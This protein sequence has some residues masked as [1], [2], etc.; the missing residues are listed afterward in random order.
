MKIY[1]SLSAIKDSLF[2]SGNGGYFHWRVHHSG[3]RRTYG[4]YSLTIDARNTTG[5]TLTHVTALPDYL[6][7][8]GFCYGHLINEIPSN[9]STGI[10]FRMYG[11]YDSLTCRL[12][13]TDGRASPQDRY[14]PCEW[15]K[16]VN[17][18]TCHIH[19]HIYTL[20][21]S[22]SPSLPDTHTHIGTS[23]FYVA[24]SNDP[25]SYIL[26]VK[27]SRIGCLGKRNLKIYFQIE[28]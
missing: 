2:I 7:R 15:L 19:T 28:T 9:V 25:G 6:Y 27:P 18:Y 1:F 13:R 24:S 26:I 4:N 16:W 10:S 3:N 21:S 14:A 8:P 11:T 23:P 12:M 20:L 17:S 5:A 22:L